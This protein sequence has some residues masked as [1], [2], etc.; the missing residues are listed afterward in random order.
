MTKLGEGGKRKL[1]ALKLGIRGC[2]LSVDEPWETNGERGVSACW[3]LTSYNIDERI[4][5][6]RSAGLWG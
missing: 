4:A 5:T 6:Y 1:L 3:V 2:W